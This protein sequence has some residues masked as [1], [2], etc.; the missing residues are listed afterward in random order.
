MLFTVK[1]TLRLKI[2]YKTEI[3]KFFALVYN[4]V[5]NIMHVCVLV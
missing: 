2:L 5:L 1:F 3:K 4:V